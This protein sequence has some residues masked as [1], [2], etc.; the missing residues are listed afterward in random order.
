MHLLFVLIAL[1]CFASCNA[2]DP[3]IGKWTI[4]APA[5]GKAHAL[6]ENSM[7]ERIVWQE[8]WFEFNDN[9]EFLTGFGDSV[10]STAEY[11]YRKDN[12]GLEVTA[13][14]KGSQKEFYRVNRRHVDTL[15]LYTIH[16]DELD[17]VLVRK[18]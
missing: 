9:G 5:G 18:K 2:P 15:Y 17:I 10:M 11:V 7:N 14:K 3:L 6:G 16:D 1:G 13:G 4:G 8:L 12:S